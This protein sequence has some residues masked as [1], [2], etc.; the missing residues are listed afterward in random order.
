MTHL[1]LDHK[2]QATPSIT[3]LIHAGALIFGNENFI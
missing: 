1:Q 3:S 2:I